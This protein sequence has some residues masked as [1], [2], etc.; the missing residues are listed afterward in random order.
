MWC[1]GLTECCRLQPA[2]AASCGG[3]LSVFAFMSSVVGV[4]D[5]EKHAGV[6]GVLLRGTDP[7]FPD[8]CSIL[9]PQPDAACT[10]VFVLLTYLLQ[11]VA[12]D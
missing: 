12:G 9:S 10:L 1:L 3:A 4:C 5:C 2:A 8:T 7:A 11:R 6:P